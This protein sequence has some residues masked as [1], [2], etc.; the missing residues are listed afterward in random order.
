[1]ADQS[2]NKAW[3]RYHINSLQ[4][5]IARLEQELATLQPSSPKEF[6]ANHLPVK[7][8]TTTPFE[9]HTESLQKAL[10]KLKSFKQQA[11][12]QLEKSES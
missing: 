12:E 10:E 6:A 7:P 9:D 11:V 5:H 4:E 3:L 1:M 8:L 2:R